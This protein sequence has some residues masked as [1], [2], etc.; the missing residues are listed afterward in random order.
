MKVIAENITREDLRSLAQ[1]F[2]GNMIKAV[3]DIDRELLA[4]DAELHA[5]LEALLLQGGSHQKDLWGINL[6]PEEQG[7]QFIEF[8]SLIN[9]RPSQNNRTRG[10]D[11]EQVRARITEI[12][13]RRVIG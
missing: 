2:F 5:D 4:V 8:D 3:V 12:V 1:N 11:N 9:V 6:Y 7:G 13:S 10:I